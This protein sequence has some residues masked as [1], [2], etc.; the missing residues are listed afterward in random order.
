MENRDYIEWKRRLDFSDG[1]VEEDSFSGHLRFGTAGI[2]GVMGIGTNR[3]NAYVVAR[4]AKAVALYL[5]KLGGGS[6]AVSYDSRIKSEAFAKTAAEVFCANGLKVYITKGVGITPLLAFSVRKLKCSAGVMITAS[7]NPRQYNGFKVYDHRGCQIGDDYAEAVWEIMGNLTYF[8]IERADF[9][10]GLKAGNIEYIG[11]KVIDSYLESVLGQ[12]FKDCKGVK[13][14]YTPLNGAGADYM[15]RLLSRL[16]A[17][18]VM[19]NEQALPDGRFSTCPYPNPEMEEAYG[20]AITRAEEEGCDIIIANDPDG[21]RIGAM[22]RSGGGFKLLSGDEIG[23]LLCSFLLEQ[24]AKK[25]KTDG[26]VIV[27][28][29]VTMRLIDKI[30]AHYGVRVEE[31]FTGF[32]HICRIASVLEERGEGHKFIAGYEES[33]GICVGTYIFDKDGVA[34]AVLLCQLAAQL[35]EEGKTF[36]DKLEELYAKFGMVKSRQRRIKADGPRGREKI[37]KV[38]AAFRSVKSYDCGGL[39]LLFT[40]DFLSEQGYDMAILEFDGGHSLAVRPS[41]T[42]PLIKL[43]LHASG[44]DCKQVFDALNKFID[45]TVAGIV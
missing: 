23:V 30:A 6:V 18:V 26:G 1:E 43:Y 31:T 44:E 5:G 14:C 32:K 29:A 37:K 12:G 4:A 28:T 38:M 45:E 33:N 34:A 9:D 35:K 11:Q 16:G 10:E 24:R 41:G 27:R 20:L 39:K 17:E 3:M 25:G 36:F 2:R 40:R 21:D 13:V 19:V 7:H 8:G 15:A 22:C 42:E